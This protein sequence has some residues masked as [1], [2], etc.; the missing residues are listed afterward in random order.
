MYWNFMDTV[1]SRVSIQNLLVE[2]KKKSKRSYLT[3]PWPFDKCGRMRM[4][5]FQTGYIERGKHSS[6]GFQDA[7]ELKIFLC[8]LGNSVASNACVNS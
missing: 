8:N 1:L 7:L 4:L 6:I 5:S 2:R 3:S